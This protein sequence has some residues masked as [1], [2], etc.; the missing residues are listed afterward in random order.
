MYGRAKDVRIKSLGRALGLHIYS[1]IFND[2]HYIFLLKYTIL[3]IYTTI[4]LR[5]PTEQE[6]N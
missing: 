2:Y 3:E 1:I 5:L 6:I 4:F